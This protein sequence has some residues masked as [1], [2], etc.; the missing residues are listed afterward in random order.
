MKK[1]LIANRGEIAIRVM[2]TCKELGIQTVA[3]YSEADK[4]APHVY[5]ADEAYLLGPPPAKESYLIIEKIVEVA[6]NSQADAIHP[7]YGFLSENSDFVDAITANG[8]IFIGPNSE[9]MN[10][11]GDKT[12]ARKLA[13]SAGVPIAPG[14][15]DSI[16]DI[17]E[18]KRISSEITYPVLLKAAGGGGGKGMRIVRQESDLES[19]LKQARSEAASSF[20]DDRIFIEKYIENPRHI[21]VQILADSFG[22][23][24][25]L[26]ERECSIQR[27]HQK[28]IEE[29][30]SIAISQ[31]LRNQITDAAV[32]LMKQAKYVNAGTVEFL[33]DCNGNFYFME[34][35]TRLQVEHPV[36]ELR[37]GID[38]VAEQIRIAEGNRLSFRQQDVSFHG[39]AIEC[40]IYA[41]DPQNDFFPSTG[42]IQWLKPSLGLG[43]REDRGVET[44]SE[45]LPYYD[46]LLSKIITF[47]KDRNEALNRMK[48]VLD[49]YELFGVETNIPF[50][51]WLMNH[52]KFQN[53]EFDTHFIANHFLKERDLTIPDNILEQAALASLLHSKHKT[54]NSVLRQERQFTSSSWKLQ[55][56]ESLH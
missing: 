16:T 21:E 25:H 32:S 28:I 54:P 43:V 38:L 19:S 45:V 56:K 18:A 27:R 4:T 15:T 17:S 2:R 46:P 49:D 13:L 6:K 1:I 52:P 34:V 33:L 41:E 30:P 50:C 9:S 26:G 3:V 48:R 37:T 39:H 51:Q 20:D 23:V 47:G 12:L 7:G 55:R 5:L 44:G 10:L 8:I 11:L 42:T 31:T 14:T 22:N 53:G 36:T 35:N 29:S 24:V 40:R